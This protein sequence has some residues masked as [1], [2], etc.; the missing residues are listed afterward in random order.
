M[1]GKE[2]TSEKYQNPYTLGLK[3]WY[4]DIKFF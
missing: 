2:S 1:H 3:K 4:Y